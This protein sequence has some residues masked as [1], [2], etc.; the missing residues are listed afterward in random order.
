MSVC[1]GK[2]GDACER[3]FV[4]VFI[5]AE[6]NQ[7]DGERGF[8]GTGIDAASGAAIPRALLDNELRHCLDPPPQKEDHTKPVSGTWPLG[9]SAEGLRVIKVSDGRDSLPGAKGKS[10][11]I[12][13]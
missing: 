4:A 10:G 1:T 8:P 12:G 9:D 13:V 5:F 7:S 6:I 11:K 2:N 3:L